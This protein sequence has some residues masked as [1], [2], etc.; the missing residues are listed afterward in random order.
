MK[1]VSD[2]E[3]NAFTSACKLAE[4]SIHNRDQK[5][6]QVYSELEMGIV[7][8]GATALEDRLQD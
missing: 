8:L 3:L 5:L 6:L 2:A 1:I 7:L 4:D